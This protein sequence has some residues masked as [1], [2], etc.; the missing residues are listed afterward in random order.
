MALWRKVKY[1]TNTLLDYKP[2][3]CCRDIVIV[4]MGWKPLLL[5]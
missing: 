5:S 4:D 2:N 1:E 3:K